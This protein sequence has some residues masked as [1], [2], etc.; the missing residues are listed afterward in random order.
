MTYTATLGGEFIYCTIDW[1]SAIYRNCSRLG[2]WHFVAPSDRLNAAPRNT[3]LQL[4]GCP[5]DTNRYNAILMFDIPIMFAQNQISAIVTHTG[6][7]NL[8]FILIALSSHCMAMSDPFATESG[9]HHDAAQNT[10]CANIQ[11]NQPL[12]LASVVN[13]TL[14]NN[15]QTREVW[16]N[17]RAQAAQVGVTQAGYLPSVSASA[18][19]TQSTPGNSQRTLGLNLSYL[20]YDFGARAANLESARQLLTSVSA[21]EDSTVQTLFLTAVQNFYQTQAAIAALEAA[22]TSERAAQESFEVARAR[23]QAG[24]A[25]PADQFA[26]QTAYSQA[27]LNRITAS[28]AVKIAQGN[29]ANMLGLDA[30]TR[31]TLTA[32]PLLNPLPQASEGER[33]KL[34]EQSITELIEE[35]RHNRPDLQAAEATLKSAEALADSA[36]A[37]AKPSISLTASSNQSNSAG[38]NTHGSSMGLSM[39]VPLFTGYAPTYRIRAAEAQIETRRAQMERIRLQVALDVWTAY[40]NLITATQNNR[41]TADLLNS[42]EQSERM[43]LGRYKAGAGIMLD[44]LNAQTTL[45][46]ARQ[47]RIQANLNWNISRAAFAQA[48]GN[49]NAGSLRTDEKIQ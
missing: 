4:N 32:A 6:C 21:T 49:L 8:T 25:T 31:I 5:R 1:M 3:F 36:R 2:M 48:M 34:F 44:V 43:A 24:S 47:Q 28:G 37:A 30:P 16:A 19:G 46:S 42:A 39:S 14:C 22:T 40:Q 15:P 9:L 45:A 7:V 29:L 23:Y 26:A 18:T 11:T 38:I 20:L 17:S 27:T 35:A 33:M 10:P 13:M 12:D 41:S